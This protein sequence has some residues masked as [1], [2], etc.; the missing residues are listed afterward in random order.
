MLEAERRLHGDN[1]SGTLI[2]MHNLGRVYQ[3]QGKYAEAEQ[4]LVQ[5]LDGYRNKLG[6]EHPGTGKSGKKIVQAY[7]SLKICIGRQLHSVTVHCVRE[8]SLP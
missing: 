8:D 4:L 6:E 1:N 2:V 3:L 7:E 5:S